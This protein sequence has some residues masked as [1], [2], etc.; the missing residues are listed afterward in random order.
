MLLSTTADIS[1]MTKSLNPSAPPFKPPTFV[2]RASARP[3][4]PAKAIVGVTSNAMEGVLQPT[5]KPM[6]DTSSAKMDQDDSDQSSSLT[7]LIQKITINDQAKQQ[8]LA[9][10]KLER[11]VY[12]TTRGVF[13]QSLYKAI[14]C[15]SSS[16]AQHILKNHVKELPVLLKLFKMEDL[17]DAVV[18]MH[19]LRVYSS[20]PDVVQQRWPWLHDGD[21]AELSLIDI[22]PYSTPVNLAFQREAMKPTF[23]GSNV[24]ANV[25]DPHDNLP[26]FKMGKHLQPPSTVADSLLSEDM[27]TMISF[28]PS[29]EAFTPIDP[30][31]SHFPYPTQRTI[32]KESQRILKTA[33]YEFAKSY[34]P[35]KL[36]LQAFEYPASSSL[37]QWVLMVQDAIST[38][39]VKDMKGKLVA[40]GL[41]Y[42]NLL[43]PA[44]ELHDLLSKRQHITTADLK[45]LLVGILKLTEILGASA[46]SAQQLALNEY[47]SALAE[48]LKK[49]LE[50]IQIPFRNA[51]KQI[52]DSKAK[53]T[54]DEEAAT[55]IYRE[56]EKL[57]QKQFLL[58][59]GV[60]KAIISPKAQS[61]DAV[62]PKPT[63]L[64][65]R[66]S[67]I[68]ISADM[69]TTPDICVWGPDKQMV[70]YRR[71]NAGMEPANAGATVY[72]PAWDP[73]AFD[74]ALEQLAVGHKDPKEN[75]STRDDDIFPHIAN[76]RNPTIPGPGLEGSRYATGNI[77][78]PPK[79]GKFAIPI[80]APPKEEF[81]T[82]KE[83]G[84]LIKL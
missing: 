36:T 65:R 33:L 69:F 50:E 71:A 82:E 13:V 44:S 9:Q 18:S 68:R 70:D 32:L 63:A 76:S 45:K 19:G 27:S 57:V 79:P 37:G 39:D 34:L 11:F 75:R 66:N 78:V 29:N 25:N 84:L 42:P 49:K 59:P 55:K 22:S 74:Q 73:A 10:Q 1:S 53:L 5:S 81:V 41:S 20:P 23:P 17:V 62:E 2:P 52:A 46:C 51:L 15:L 43:D 21:V 8:N 47:T 30:Y 6:F 4:V 28:D 48:D 80:K 72:H 31:S 61:T 12:L 38:A 24:G 54:R 60:L 3:F 58:D 83:N 35:D 56:K 77:F 26:G 67:I 7:E 14:T 40:I 16:T 64:A